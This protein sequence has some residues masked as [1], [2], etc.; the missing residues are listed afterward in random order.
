MGRGAHRISISLSRRLRLALLF[1]SARWNCSSIWYATA[2]QTSQR[3]TAG[4][5]RDSLS[6]SS[7]C[8]GLKLILVGVGSIISSASA[9]EALPYV[10][11]ST[12]PALSAAPASSSTRVAAA[13]AFTCGALRPHPSLLGVGP[14]GQAAGTAG[15]DGQAARGGGQG[16]SSP[17]TQR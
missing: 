13:I 11:S 8:G 14:W 6:S 17:P 16:G 7:S 2:A 1:F 3:Y 12:A 15:T 5:V 4:T 9:A 10:T